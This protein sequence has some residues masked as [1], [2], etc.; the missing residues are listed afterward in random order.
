VSLIK[1][2]AEVHVIFYRTISRISFYQCIL[3]FYRL[4]GPRV[5]SIEHCSVLLIANGKS[6]QYHV[7]K[8]CKSRWINSRALDKFTPVGDINL[9]TIEF[10][11]K[12]LLGIKSVKFQLIIYFFWWFFIRWWG[13]WYPKN[14]CSV[15]T[16]EILNK[17]GFDIKE[18]PVPIWLWDELKGKYESGY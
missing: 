14:N 10:D 8:R 13:K 3:K 5:T 18:T 12:L 11:S 16:C 2:K 4:F 1:A 9:G 15:K 17:L 7:G 6:T